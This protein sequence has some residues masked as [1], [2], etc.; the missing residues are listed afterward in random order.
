[1]TNETDNMKVMQSKGLKRKRTVQHSGFL[2]ASALAFT[3]SYAT[4]FQN[5]FNHM[6]KP[7][8][9]RR[10][11]PAKLHVVTDPR[12]LMFVD[13]EGDDRF[14]RSA[15]EDMYLLST[16]SEGLSGM[17]IEN[18]PVRQSLKS[19]DKSKM[20]KENTVEV[21]EENVIS[22]NRLQFNGLSTTVNKRARR[23]SS[24]RRAPV[25]HSEESMQRRA[26][27]RNMSSTM[28]G[29]M[30]RGNSDRQK[31]FRDG[32]KIAEHRSGK[33]Y[34]DTEAAK[35]KRRQIN[36]EHMYRT[37][38]SV[39]DSMLQFANEIHCVDRITPAEEITLGEKTQEAIRLQAAYDKLVD[40]FD[41]EP[42]DD[43]WC[44]ASGKI[45]MEAISQ[46][47]EE[48]LEAKNKLVESNLRMVQGVVNVYI[49][50]GL[51]GQYNAGDLMQ[52]G[53]M[54]RMDRGIQLWSHVFSHP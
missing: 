54:V 20:K 26:P 32:I 31:A 28:P 40:K 25:I 13:T 23:K 16:D 30:E 9:M 17:L 52:E 42:T 50:N 34:L 10:A 21:L 44:A 29:F 11:S 36:G 27:T 5:S 4:A 46:A 19:R 7:A 24:L 38:A 53:I 47:I 8:D 41:R 35:M 14:E 1:M 18:P 2:V 48:G 3:M 51:R 22:E 15:L 12:Q 45:N 33:K 39:P 37:S 43:E 49:R 6:R